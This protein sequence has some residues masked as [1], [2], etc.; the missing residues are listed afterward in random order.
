MIAF[1]RLRLDD[2]SI[3]LRGQD[4]QHFFD[5]LARPVTFNRKLTEA[6]AEHDRRVDSQ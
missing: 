4:A 6:L 3:I 2:Q 5:A 1:Q